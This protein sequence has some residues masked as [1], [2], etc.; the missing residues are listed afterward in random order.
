MPPTGS[1]YAVRTLEAAP[2][3]GLG[4]AGDGDPAAMRAIIAT[5]VRMRQRM[6][7]SAAL[8]GCIVWLVAGTAFAQ[9]E[10][11]QVA[12]IM[13]KLPP[14]ETAAYKSI[15]KQ[16]GNA[17]GQVLTL[18]KTEVWVV[19][20]QNVEAVKKAAAQHGA[21][22]KQLGEDWNHVLHT[23]PTELKMSDKQKEMMEVA[24]ASK[25]TTGVGMV[26]APD[27]PSVEYALTKDANSQ[28]PEKGPA[29]IAVRL[30]DTTVLTVTRT[31]VDIKP[32]MCVWR[33]T[34]DGTD[35][36]ATIMWWPGGKMAGSL[37]H[38]GRIYSIRHMGGELH[39][40]IE[41]SEDRMPQEHAPAPGRKRPD[42]PNMRDG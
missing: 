12:L 19:P 28:A 33:G 25:S 18:T 30:S 42:D 37:K 21:S 3:G 41:M 38:E 35:A 32:D 29:K 13:I 14:Q 26:T 15:R 2:P 23:L 7:R 16:A 10:A 9:K 20:K 11:E 24:K 39:A 5:M 17:T 36:P 6:I 40:V 31:R 8:L 4:V 34:V 27:A 22:V 1:S